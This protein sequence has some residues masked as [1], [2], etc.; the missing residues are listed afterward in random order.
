MSAKQSRMIDSCSNEYS[1]ATSAHSIASHTHTQPVFMRACEQAFRHPRPICTHPMSLRSVLFRFSGN[2][3]LLLGL[4][5]MAF[6]LSGCVPGDLGDLGET[7]PTLTPTSTPALDLDEDGVSV[8]GGDCDDNDAS[9]YPGATEL[10]DKKDNDCNEAVDDGPETTGYVDS[11]GDQYGAG[12]E[13]HAYCDP[14]SSPLVTTGGDCDDSDAEIN[15]GAD[16]VCDLSDNDCDGDIDENVQTTWYRDADSDSFGDPN[17]S[18][19]DCDTP[20]RGYV[21]NALDCDDDSFSINPNQAEVCDTIDNNC[22]TTIDEGVQIAF[23]PDKDKD[24]QGAADADAVFACNGG[25]GTVPNNSD[26][27]DADATVYQDAPEKCDLKDND[28]DPLIDEGYSTLESYPDVDQDGYGDDTAEATV[29]CMIPLGYAGNATDCNDQ[30]PSTYPDAQELCDGRDNDCDGASDELEDLDE[31]GYYACDPLTGVTLDCDDDDPSIYPS[32]YDVFADG[33][34]GNCNGYQDR[35]ITVAG[36][37][38]AG[39]AGDDGLATQANLSKPSEIRFGPDGALFIADSKNNKIRRVSKD[40][41]ITTVAGNG[42]GGYSGDGGPAIN[43]QLNLPNGVLFDSLGNMYIADS[44]NNRIR[45]VSPEGIILTFA[46]TGSVIGLGDGGLATAASLISP[47]GM[48]IDSLDRIFVADT[49]HNRIRLIENSI[50]STV[51]GNGS[52]GFSG[53][54]GPANAAKIASP[55]SVALGP[56]N[57]FFIADAGNNRIRRVDENGVISTFAGNGSTQGPDEEEGDGGLAIEASLNRPVC[58][59]FDLWDN[60][61]IADYSHHRIRQVTVDGVIHTV[62]GTGQAGY[63]GDGSSSANSVINAPLAVTRSV[64]GYILFSDSENNRVRQI[65]W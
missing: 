26:C 8:A 55:T 2:A 30:D 57:N 46:G 3:C 17:A 9:V 51:A 50:I 56:D 14:D 12:R 64:E 21:D 11:D 43:A 36:N 16:E 38:V 59:I 33:H 31:D 13:T 61:Y 49:G 1:R 62:A 52:S 45:R 34:D 25:A 48:A 4:W 29:A 23:Y 32:A 6:Q 7:S 35:I 28:C 37:G 54:G 20:P 44:F 10:C 24:G 40:G 53:D 19:D 63:A 22:N 18:K 27:N 5:L 15:P 39:S 42:T 65:L 47:A 58:L 60:L 41:V